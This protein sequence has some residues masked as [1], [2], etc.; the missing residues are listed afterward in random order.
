[1]PD[2]MHQIS[3]LLD[4]AR[5]EAEDRSEAKREAQKKK[6]IVSVKL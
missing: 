3:F 4:V 2:E 5:R 1:M 6:F